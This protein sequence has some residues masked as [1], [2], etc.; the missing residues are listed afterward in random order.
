[1]QLLASPVWL[2]VADG[3]VLIETTLPRQAVS[4]LRL[5]W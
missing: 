2:D 5:E 4:L 3:K 1:L